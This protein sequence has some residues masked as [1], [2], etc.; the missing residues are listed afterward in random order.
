AVIRDSEWSGLDPSIMG[1]GPAVSVGRLMDRHQF[2]F[3][4]LDLLELNEAFAAQVL[5]C[6]AAW[7]DSEFCREVLGRDTVLGVLEDT[8]LNIHGDAIALGH[9]LG[10]SGYRIVLHL[11][12][13]LA[14]KQ[15]KRGIATQ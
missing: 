13:A 14:Q 10:T 4:D 11:A 6:L 8:R 5:G 7:N 9:P 12:N 1:L 15:L 2:G 3:G